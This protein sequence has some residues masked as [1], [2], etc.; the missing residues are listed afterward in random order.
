M[1]SRL[2]T[3][4]QTLSISGSKQQKIPVTVVDEHMHVLPYWFDQGTQAAPLGATLVLSLSH[5]FRISLIPV[6][7]LPSYSRCLSCCL[8]NAASVPALLSRSRYLSLSPDVSL[9]R[10]YSQ[11][12]CLDVLLFE[13]AFTRCTLMAIPTWPP[14]GEWLPD[15]P[16]E[17]APEGCARTTR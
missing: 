17:P 12:C 15:G 3:K 6:S 4:K 2:A 14:Q 10:S 11:P 13:V 8:P 5:C 7:A 16:Q 1:L 9:T